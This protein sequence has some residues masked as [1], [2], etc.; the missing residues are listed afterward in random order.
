MRASYTEFHERQ[1]LMKRDNRNALI[2]GT[3]IETAYQNG[4]MPKLLPG[5]NL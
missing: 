1:R 3:G 4:S 5:A 2:G